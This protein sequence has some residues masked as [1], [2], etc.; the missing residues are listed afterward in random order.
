MTAA[1]PILPLPAPDPSRTPDAAHLDR[2]AGLLKTYTPYDGSHELRLPGVYAVRASR[3]NTELFHAVYRPSLCVVA[4]GAKTL[5]LG[6]EV[7]EY[8]ASRM[9]VVSVDLP[10]ASQVTQAS[11]AEPFL[12]L[13]LDLDPQRIA[14]LAL[15]VYPNGVPRVRENRGVYLGQANA[16]IVAAATRLMEL[17]ADEGDARLIAPLV[18]DELLIRLLRSPVG[19]RVAQIGQV[20]SSVHRIAKAVEWVRA[21]FDEPLNVEALAEMV[22]MSPSSFHEHFKAVTSMSPLQY[23]K[24]LRLREARRLL[25]SST[26]D[27]GTAGRQVG[28]VSASQFSREYSRLFGQAPTRD[29]ARLRELGPPPSSVA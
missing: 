20:E 2:L 10:V 11:F 21:H 1:N 27:A 6:S 14:E 7:Y 15:R 13:K 28:Y 17:M 23:Q 5:F 22:Y 25:L 24:V 8:D 26:M 18:I 29:V 12:S 9:L 4:Q 19:N 16:Q 3:I